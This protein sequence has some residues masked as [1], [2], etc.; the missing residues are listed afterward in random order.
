V[1]KSAT[2]GWDN[3]FQGGRFATGQVNSVGKSVDQSGW[4]PGPEISNLFRSNAS[5]YASLD[6]ARDLPAGSTASLV[7]LG[8]E[9]RRY[10][11][12]A[13]M[14]QAAMLLGGP[15]RG[16]TALSALIR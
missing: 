4:N 6:A 5:I 3:L 2:S 9:L 1:L 7:A 11:N 13:Q 12:N 16:D 15:G 8:A 14:A 10:G